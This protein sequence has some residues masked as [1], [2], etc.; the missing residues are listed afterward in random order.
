MT[1]SGHE[2][3]KGYSDVDLPGE[4]GI[5]NAVDVT[6]SGHKTATGHVESGIDPRIATGLPKSESERDSTGSSPKIATTCRRTATETRTA[7]D[8]LDC[9]R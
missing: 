2:S 6:G 9:K 8:A 3:G 7:S 5:A 1:S 4:Q